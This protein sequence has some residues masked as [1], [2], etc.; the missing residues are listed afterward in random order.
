LVCRESETSANAALVSDSRQSCFR[1]QNPAGGGHI[2]VGGYT[3]RTRFQSLLK[4]VARPAEPDAALLR[5]FADGRDDAAF[6]ELVRRYGRLVWGQCRNL[7]PTEAD[8]DDA[9]QAT[10]V[11]LARS[12]D[13]IRDTNKLGP[14]LHGV[15]YRV[16]RNAR[17]VA[18]RRIKREQGS[19]AAEAARPVADS[20]W[21]SALAAVHDELHQ[22][23]ETLRVPFVLCCLEGKGT[24]EAAEQLGLKLGTFSARLTR[25]KQALLDRLS[26]RGLSAGVLAAAAV[27]GGAASA[28]AQVLNR[29]VE[30]ATAAGTIPT[31]ILSLTHG[32]LGMGTLN[33]KLMAAAVLVS[34]GLMAGVGGVWTANAQDPKPKKDAAGDTQK[35]IDALKKQIDELRARAERAANQEAA[36]RDQAEATAQKEL[37]VRK[38]A[39]VQAQRAQA[40]AERARA[41]D[42]EKLARRKKEVDEK[43]DK[44]R[45]AE[46]KYLGQSAGFA[47]TAE[48]LEELVKRGEEGGYRFVGVVSMKG[49]SKQGGSAVPTLVFRKAKVVELRTDAGGRLL[50]E[51]AKLETA[52]LF[53]KKAAEAQAKGAVEKLTDAQGRLKEKLADLEG[54]KK[55]VEPKVKEVLDKV[56]EIEPK[57]KEAAKK[58]TDVADEKV[59]E[60]VKDRLAEVAKAR[61]QEDKMRA[62]LDQ[63]H[64]ELARLKSGQAEMSAAK[65]PGKVT[66]KFA[67]A[68]LGKGDPAAAARL[69]SDLARA[70]FGKVNLAID[71]TDDGYTVS[72]D[73]EVVKWLQETV[74]QLSS[75]KSDKSK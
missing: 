55:A 8:A 40:D 72:G 17:R 44:V 64:Q 34:C 14:W 31:N 46:F 47:P 52:E 27:T 65:A 33:G 22:L 6:A 9:F 7:L 62:E 26:A 18:A 60:A 25:A 24:T 74:K 21:D 11:A 38:M 19:A 69:L 30:L 58:A 70:K 61:G 36:A 23:P 50:E 45:S 15:A 42:A 56:K 67:A 53:H 16:C 68:D 39:E 37:A 13:K 3:V 73:A 41:Q 10:F 75:P 49:T 20:A 35:E 63:L 4:Q 2:P 48:E 71:V 43:A 54:V 12:A 1:V 5:R 59:K 51:K 57:V 28:P 66:A 29:A 32:V